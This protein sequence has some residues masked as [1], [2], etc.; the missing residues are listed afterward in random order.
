MKLL[1]TL[2]E[3]QQQA[4][5]LRDG[6]TIWYCVPV[7]LAFDNRARSPVAYTHLTLPTILRV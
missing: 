3:S 5:S 7:D 2:K 1:Y 6:E 4:L